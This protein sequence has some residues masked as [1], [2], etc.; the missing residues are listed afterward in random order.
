MK[1]AFGRTRGIP[2]DVTTAWGARLIAPDDLLHDRQDLVAENA[3]AKAE[4]VK[5]L[6]GGAIAQMRDWLRENYWQFRQDDEQLVILE[7]AEGTIVGSTQASGGYVYVSGWLKPDRHEARELREIRRQTPIGRMQDALTVAQYEVVRGPVEAERWHTH[8][9]WSK[10]EAEKFGNGSSEVRVF[11]VYIDGTRR[12]LES[13]SG[14]A[15]EFEMGYGGSGPHET[16]RA[17]V[18]DREGGDRTP[19]DLQRLVPEV[20]APAGRESQTLVVGAGAV[21]A[22]LREAA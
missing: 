12:E 18:A 10:A 5:W 4:L 22:R 14:R 7:D 16:A 13:S 3:E 2:D 11:A 6:N 19:A 17:I 15:G 21:D 1:L 20:F 9:G 8:Y